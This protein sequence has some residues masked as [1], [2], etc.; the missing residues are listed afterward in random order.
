MCKHAQ[1]NQLPETYRAIP[2][3]KGSGHAEK[4]KYFSQ[5]TISWKME[6]VQ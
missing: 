4:Q 5:P 2:E 6:H 1:G 3:K